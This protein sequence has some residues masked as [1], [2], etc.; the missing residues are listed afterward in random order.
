MIMVTDIYYFSGTGNSLYVSRELEARIPDSNL[1]PIVSVL[2]G[3][4]KN[5]MDKKTVAATI[6]FVFPCH[7]LTIPVPVKKFLKSLEFI[8]LN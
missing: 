3:L 2:N 6:G 5:K 1:I 7:G 8:A 4:N